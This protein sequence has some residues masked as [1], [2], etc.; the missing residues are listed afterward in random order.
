MQLMPH[1]L[2]KAGLRVDT[3]KIAQRDMITLQWL[4]WNVLDKP[5]ALLVITLQSVTCKV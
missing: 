3:S 5:V 4:N 1:I 2:Q